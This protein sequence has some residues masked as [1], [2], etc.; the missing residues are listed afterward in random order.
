MNGAFEQA[1]IR[2]AGKYRL[3]SPAADRGPLSDRFFMTV[4]FSDHPVLAGG[5][6]ANPPPTKAPVLTVLP[7][8]ILRP[9]GVDVMRFYPTAAKAAKLEGR[10][11]IT[12]RV[13]GEGRLGKCQLINEAPAGAGF[14]D[15]ALALADRFQMKPVDKNGMATAGQDVRIPFKFTLPS[16]PAA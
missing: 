11:T 16:A 1:A 12:C 8:W 15:A 13:D 4:D 10:A 5:P 3:A 9:D 6:P 2:V 7:D 14:G